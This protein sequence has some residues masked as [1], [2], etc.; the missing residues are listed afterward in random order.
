MLGVLPR[1]LR[2]HTLRCVP[3][4]YP[5]QWLLSVEQKGHGRAFYDWVIIDALVKSPLHRLRWLIENSRTKAQWC[6]PS[7]GKHIACGAVDRY[8]FTVNGFLRIH[9]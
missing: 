3:L 7:G 5:E 9:P 1:T 8:R 6:R 4:F 2:A